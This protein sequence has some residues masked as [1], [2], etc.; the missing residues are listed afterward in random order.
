MIK[1]LS[2][3]GW[4]HTDSQLFDGAGREIITVATPL[5]ATVTDKWYGENFCALSGEIHLERCLEN[6]NAHYPLTTPEQRFELLAQ[7]FPKV[8]PKRLE[9]KA[10]DPQATANYIKNGIS[11]A[12]DHLCTTAEATFACPANPDEL[13][14]TLRLVGDIFQGN[15]FAR[16]PRRVCNAYEQV[17]WKLNSEEISS[18]VAEICGPETDVPRMLDCA[19]CFAYLIRGPVYTS[20]PGYIAAVTNYCCAVCISRKPGNRQAALDVLLTIGECWRAISM[21]SHFPGDA[22]IEIT[23]DQFE[24]FTDGWTNG[25]KC[26]LLSAIASQNWHV[27]IQTLRAAARTG[28]LVQ[29]AF[30]RYLASEQGSGGAEKYV[31]LDARQLIL[32]SPSASPTVMGKRRTGVD[33]FF[34][35]YDAPKSREWIRAACESSI[36]NDLTIFQDLFRDRIVFEYGGRKVLV[37][38]ELASRFPGRPIPPSP[39]EF[40]ISLLEEN[41]SPDEAFE[42][43]QALCKYP[44]VQGE[45]ARIILL[46]RELRG[47]LFAAKLFDVTNPAREGED[48][49]I[50]IRFY[51]GGSIEIEAFLY[52]VGIPPAPNL[53]DAFG[54]EYCANPWGVLHTRITC[55]SAGTCVIHDAAIAARV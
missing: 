1:N 15:G 36:V 16:L 41:F 22:P 27:A 3:F 25:E 35:Q 39:V 45:C 46:L 26:S 7:L 12:L 29:R 4:H 53:E 14:E 30:W 50:I 19:P 43:F 52:R 24:N 21:E 47:P 28:T 49:I 48:A 17:Y 44:W 5:W 37:R 6:I 55:D 38:D 2:T 33:E 54:V 11:A 32:R 20:Y 9:E 34:R 31:N 23:F 13:K 42:L 10:R 40:T 8:P 51:E 18:G